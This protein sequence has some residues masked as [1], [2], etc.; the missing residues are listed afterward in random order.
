MSCNPLYR[1][2]IAIPLPDRQRSVLSCWSEV[3]QER[4]PFQTW[5]HPSD[6]HI[7]VQFLGACTFRQAREVK[8]E[9]KHVMTEQEPFRLAIRKLGIFGVPTRPRVL[10]AG[11]GGDL[12]CLQ[13]LYDTVINRVEPLG[14]E[15]EK[16]AYKPHI[17]LAKKYKRNDFPQEELPSLFSCGEEDLSWTVDEM[18]LYQTHLYQSPMY[19]PLAQFDM[20]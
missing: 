18:V 5:V 17:T 9:L 10:W 2:F 20:G 4:W 3:M 16:R 6:Y 11:L 13:A 19:Q 14:F 8:R 12:D 7:T 1:L 15:K